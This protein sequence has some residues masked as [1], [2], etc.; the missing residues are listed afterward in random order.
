[1]IVARERTSLSCILL[2]IVEQPDREPYRDP[3]VKDVVGTLPEFY[4]AYCNPL[5]RLAP[6]EAIKCLQREA[7]CWKPLES[8]CA[9]P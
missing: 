4:C 6:S 3:Q 1:M 7:P 9:T 8:I 2:H 5:K